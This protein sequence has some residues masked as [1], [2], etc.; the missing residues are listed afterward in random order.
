MYNRPYYG[1]EEAFFGAPYPWGRR[2]P[3]PTR[4]YSRRYNRYY[5][6]GPQDGVMLGPSWSPQFYPNQPYYAYYGSAF[7]P[8]PNAG[9]GQLN[10]F[11]PVPQHKGRRVSP[12]RRR[13][14]S[15]PSHRQQ[16]FGDRFGVPASRRKESQV[17]ESQAKPGWFETNFLLSNPPYHRSEHPDESDPDLI[18]PAPTNVRSP[19]SSLIKTPDPGRIPPAKK[20]NVIQKFLPDATIGIHRQIVDTDDHAFNQLECNCQ[21]CDDQHSYY[22]LEDD[23]NNNNKL[24]DL[25]NPPKL[26][27][28]KRRDHLHLLKRRKS[29]ARFL[30]QEECAKLV[31]FRKFFT[32]YN[33][34][35]VVHRVNQIRREMLDEVTYDE[36]GTKSSLKQKK[37]R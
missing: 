5:A 35:E 27:V 18:R 25:S 8:D 6:V 29:R 17:L 3:Q 33:Q 11:Q 22:N 12:N 20:F 21:H 31:K 32:H 37:I 16:S 19:V 36:E 4:R 14:P 23:P 15:P 24:P 30:N 28:A 10:V 34:F 26:S 2:P 9:W 7:L 1:T 13:R